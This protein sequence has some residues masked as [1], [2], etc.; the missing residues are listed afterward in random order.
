MNKSVCPPVFGHFV[1]DP[2]G[3]YEITS[4][5]M[6]T[7]WQYIYQNGQILLRADQF[8]PVD[9]QLCPPQDIQLFRRERDEKYSRWCVWLRSPQLRG[10]K[11]F[12]NF[13]RPVT[14]GNP[15]QTPEDL[16]VRFSPA[17]AVYSSRVEGLSV[18]TSFLIP[19]KGAGIR[20]EFTAHNET[21]QTLELELTPVLT[22]YVSPARMEPWDKPEW[23]LKT[24][25]GREQAA[26]FY[27]RLYN[28]AS[29]ASQ[30]RAA[31]LWSTPDGLESAALSLEQF[32]GAG[33]LARP[34]A[35]WLAHLPIGL[36]D[37][38]A[39]GELDPAHQLYGYPPVYALR[40]RFVL[41]PGE[42]A[43]VCQ[44]LCAGL[45]ASG[46]PSSQLPSAR[47]AL[48]LLTSSAAEREKR[49]RQQYFAQL[50]SRRRIYTDDAAL[51]RYLNEWLPLQMHWAAALDRGWP[52]G[53]R[54][55]RD[56]AND[57]M[58]CLHLD[59]AWCRQIL[60]L[61]MECQRSDGWFPRQVSTKGRTGQHDLRPFVDGGAFVMEALYSYLCVT[62]DRQLL[63]QPVV[64]LDDETAGTVLEHAVRAVEYYCAPDNIGE[65]GLCK[66]RGGDWLDA[67]NRAG[68]EGR[69]ESVM[70]TAQVVMAIDYLDAMGRMAGVPTPDF[71]AQKERFRQA[72]STEAWDERGFFR[73]VFTDAG[74]WVFSGSDPD[75]ACRPYACANAYAL[76][77]GAADGKQT[78]GTV[79]ALESL[80][81]PMGYRL[82]TPPLG[83][84]PIAKLGRSGS[85]DGLEG[86]FENGAPYNHGSHGFVGR[87]M[88]HAGKPEQ[89][90]DLLRCML[91]C[92][93][94]RH[95]TEQALTPPY[96][97]VNC[98]QMIPGFTGQGV[99]PPL[100]HP[101]QQQPHRSVCRVSDRRTE[102][103]GAAQAA[104][105]CF[106]PGF[107]RCSR[108]FLLLLTASEKTPLQT[109]FA[110]QQIVALQKYS[111]G[112]I[113]MIEKQQ[114]GL[115]DGRHLRTYPAAATGCRDDTGG[116][117][118]SSARDTAGR[119]EL[120]EPQNAARYRDTGCDRAGVFSGSHRA[121]A[122]EPPFRLDKKASRPDC[123]VWERRSWVAA[124]VAFCTPGRART[125]TPDLQL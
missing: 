8:G 89:V 41:Q 97:M 59:P 21:G 91:P 52:T 113:M 32:M 90:L 54:G 29:D 57:L 25:L 34:E 88:A 22:P 114:G 44:V 11:P 71:S 35:V 46:Q 125:F 66:I 13:G 93:L 108:R 5:D 109:F 64:W 27:T 111:P 14:D 43:T 72:A 99:L 33:D 92:S 10:G 123:G 112:A 16:K 48:Q 103:S 95:P 76:L 7:S 101:V 31:A 69:G 50:F 87:A 28:A 47:R 122:R 124:V 6:Q 24:G 120:G 61:V 100:Q 63:R 39:Y 83:R 18:R 104:P 116:T 73:G 12:C 23:Y 70:V 42:K 118:R 106:F 98:W 9:A 20:M 68:L 1:D 96:A 38:G 37:W 60:L 86:L 105:L 65:H 82:F 58:G 49:Q 85:G 62:G 75:G 94:D 17:E 53:M 67:V 121:F 15:N 3:T 74:Q 19:E 30:R 36:D 51:D 84:S 119:L 107:P 26:V 110:A 78:A 81:T 115:C 2:P 80:R 4:L 55:T 45:T 117:G 77:C 102:K 79:A 56:C 40:Y